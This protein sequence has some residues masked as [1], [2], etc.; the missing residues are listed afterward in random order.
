MK[1]VIIIVA[2]LMLSACG[3][4]EAEPSE[5]R[6][7]Q[8]GEERISASPVNPNATPEAQRLYRLLYSQYGKKALSG[9]VANVDWNTREAENVH[10]WTGHWPA[11]NVFDFINI[12]AS[13]DV[14]LK[15]AIR[16]H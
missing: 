1:N 11:I 10:Q 5:E 14:N 3:K 2:V 13:K 12:H 15:S 8:A 4:A 9:V 16:S 6:Q 7:E